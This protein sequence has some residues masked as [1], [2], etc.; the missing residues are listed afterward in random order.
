MER[1]AHLNRHPVTT[2]TS[3]IMLS[4]HCLWEIKESDP[5]SNS[6]TNLTL[7]FLDWL[8]RA[9]KSS[10]GSL[11]KIALCYRTIRFFWFQIIELTV[12]VSSSS[13]GSWG[14]QGA[15]RA[16]R[17]SSS[18]QARFLCL[19]F[20]FALLACS[21]HLGHCFLEYRLPSSSVAGRIFLQL[22]LEHRW[23]LRSGLAFGV[24]LIFNE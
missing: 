15:S 9:T 12:S 17:G 18:S 4:T 20:A 22:G 7:I 19:A 8:R 13:V 23:G 10:C 11:N 16:G 6:P 5:T 2:Q 24:E 1:Q 14:G 21:R 3:L